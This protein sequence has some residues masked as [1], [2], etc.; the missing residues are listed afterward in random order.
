MAKASLRYVLRILMTLMLAPFPVLAFSHAQAAPPK[1]AEVEKR[2]D[3]IL[4]RMTLEE[5]ID[6]IGGYNA[7]YVRAIKRLGLPALKMAD[8]PIGV[9][10]YGPSTA[11]AAGIGLAA[12]WDT[13]LAG[14]VG[15]MIGRDAR[16]RG[17]HFLLGPGV[18][19][20]RAPMCGR[21]FE[22]YGEDPFLAARTAVAYIKGVQAQGVSA[23]IKH[24][25]GNNS[26]FDRH[27]T[28][29]EIDERT[30]REIYLPTFEA[31]VKEANVGAIMNSYNLVN[32]VH[33][34]QNPHINVDIA[35]KEWGFDGVMMSDWDATYDA[36]AAAN[37]GLDLEMPSGKFMNRATL[38]PAVREGKVS[39]ATIDDKVRRILRKAV[40]FGWLD[41]EQTD[42]SW[43]L[44][45]EQGRAVALESARAG[46]VL[47]KNDGGL[48]PLDKAKLKTVAVIGPDAYPAV[49]VGGG[50]AQVRPFSAVSY[51]QGIADYLGGSAT[52]LYNRGVVP[53]SEIFD[54]SEWATEASAGQLG[55][56]AEYFT[57][58]SFEGTP[59]VSRV[60]EH[61]SFVWD[62]PN[63]WPAGG[64]AKNVSAR[65]SGYFVPAISGAY[66][67]VAATY[68]LDDYRVYVDG[69]LIIERAQQNHPIAIK[70]MTLQAAKPYAVR[71]EYVHHDHH[72][73]L[74]F[75]V[76]KADLFA[77]PEARV[78]ASRADAVIVLAGFDPS[79]ESE[80]Y[81]RTFELP[82]GQDDLIEAASRANKHTVV[83][84]T[85]GGAVDMSRWLGH[86]PALMQ[87]WY[88][89]QEAGVALAQLLFGDA[90]PS[91]K[92]PV[93]FER[94]AEDGATY[95]SY[96]PGADKKIVYSEGV[97][98]GYRHFDKTGIEPLF[99]FGYGLS[100][101]T[102]K[103][104]GLAVTPDAMPAGGGT[105]TVSFDVTNTGRREGA[106][107]AQ[108]Y[109]ADQHAALPRPPK[110]L[111]GFAK[112]H[113][114]PGETRRVQI[115]LDRRAFSYFDPKANAWRADPG[116]FQLLVGS[117]SQAIELR[118]KVALR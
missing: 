99:P 81:D 35:K 83:V 76:R 54:G 69:M 18:N 50:S 100:Y 16:A 72:A 28:S 67:F 109:V 29:S 23:T 88:A 82:I 46:M 101:T 89:G 5:K 45:S 111:K 34:T 53:L 113:L 118:G 114:K 108:L 106:E 6:Y 112:V 78:V 87:A 15:A 63:G 27:H 12:S 48:L 8:G 20:H 40:E 13:D 41:H 2:V 96:Y 116:E 59:A 117:S 74:G 3:A 47:L 115:A 52:V 90:S 102:F 60:D 85:S 80:G 64:A 103:Y 56:K 57:N 1:P 38:V 49:P 77:D 91:G 33:A 31:A 7:F 42:R 107:V 25:L 84:M 61:V 110:E 44:F 22:Y 4:R 36:V 37:A 43:P 92:L 30:L 93:S 73:R 11:Y 21:N 62:R 55:L 14:R 26:E 97:F 58:P 98:L 70:E 104:S 65:W 79:N 17:V 9:R 68:G 51:L 32:G 105:V 39:V 95:K 66:R 24:F 10:N 75:G 94:R 19:I 86:V 71:L